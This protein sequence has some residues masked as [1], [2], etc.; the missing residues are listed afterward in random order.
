MLY[1]DSV[2]LKKIATPSNV[3]R[4]M[5]FLASHRAAGHMT[6]EVISVDGGMEGR[7]LWR[8]S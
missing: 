4:T 5:A 1:N 7:L 6:G 8:R 2:A 3:A